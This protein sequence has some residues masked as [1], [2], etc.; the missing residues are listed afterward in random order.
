MYVMAIAGTMG[1]I[2]SARAAGQQAQNRINEFMLNEDLRSRQ[3]SDQSWVHVL[4]QAERWAANK[5]IAKDALSIREKTKFWNRIRYENSTSEM[6][7]GMSKAYS[8]LTSQLSGRIGTDSA[9]S[10]ALLRNSM[11]NYYSAR[12]NINITEALKGRSIEETYR[13]TLNTRDFGFNPVGEYYPGQYAGVDPSTARS[14][15]F[16]QGLAGTAGNM[17]SASAAGG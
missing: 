17:A 12:D 5:A 16:I 10:R 3:W 1:A 4:Q 2:G 11:Q 7:K 8:D 15:A 14:H 9:T 6:S 13:K